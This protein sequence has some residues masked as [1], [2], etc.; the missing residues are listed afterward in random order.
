MAHR[1]IGVGET[2]S[3]RYIGVEPPISDASAD[4]ILKIV[5]MPKWMIWGM[6][7]HTEGAEDSPPYTEFGADVGYALDTIGRVAVDEGA[8]KL[9]QAIAGILET[10]GD[11]VEIV[12]P[13]ITTDFEHP[14]FGNQADQERQIL[15]AIRS[16][17]QAQ[18]M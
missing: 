8:M 6:A 7:Y 1:R 3:F 10:E 16:H 5:A 11:T 12:E 15:A 14:I 4:R 9:A 2:S 17:H 18:D 13:M